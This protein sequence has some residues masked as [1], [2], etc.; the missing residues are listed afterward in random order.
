MHAA[1]CF[2]AAVRACHAARMQ[3]IEMG[4]DTGVSTVFTV[5]RAPGHGCV[6]SV[7]ARSYVLTKSTLHR[8]ICRDVS[9]GS[10]GLVVAA[11]RR[12]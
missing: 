7:V 3:V 6:T 4:V 1:T 2:V 5:R 9:V 11:C 12:A 10:D 8:Q